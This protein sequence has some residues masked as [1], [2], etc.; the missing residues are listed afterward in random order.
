MLY[1]VLFIYL[2]NVAAQKN[3][4]LKKFLLTE[5]D[6]WRLTSDKF[7]EFEPHGPAGKDMNATFLLW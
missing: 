7:R 5:F 6:F 2:E 1:L 4:F 3:Q